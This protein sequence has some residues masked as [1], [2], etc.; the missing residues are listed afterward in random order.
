[1][2][3]KITESLKK[4]SEKLAKAIAIRSTEKMALE[5]QLNDLDNEVTMLEA[6]IEIHKESR[7]KYHGELKE[8]KMKKEELFEIRDKVITEKR[9]L[10][11]LYNESQRSD[12]E[13]ATRIEQASERIGRIIEQG[14]TSR[15][16]CPILR[17]DFSVQCSGIKIV[18]Q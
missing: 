12:Q 10:Q 14:R 3:D 9:D 5:K 6:K 13:L 8:W 11:T 17:L 18:M 15:S 16:A 1:M 2:T 7:D 4:S